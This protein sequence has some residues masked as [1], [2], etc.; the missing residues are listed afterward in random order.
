[1]KVSPARAA[2]FDA[3]LRVERDAAF[4][5]DA[6]DARLE[7]L[8]QRADAALA[9]ELT[10]GVLRW[11][12]LIDFLLERLT[13]RAVAALD[14]EVL[15]GLRLGLYQLRFLSRVPAS[16]AVNESV[17]LVKRARKSSAAGLV[18]ATL[19]RAARDPQLRA[20]AESLVPQDLSA[21]EQLGLA[22]SHPTW[23]VE[24]WLGRYGAPA[25]REL[26]EANNQPPRL[27]AAVMDSE[28]EEEARVS[29]EKAGFDVMPGRWLASAVEL[30]RAPRAGAFRLRDALRVGPL[31][32]QD[33][34]SQMIPLLLDV[35]A[36]QRVLDLCAAPGGKT[37]RLARRAGQGTVVAADVHLHR[38]RPMRELLERLGAEIVNLVALDGTQPLPF[39]ARFD[40]VLVDAPC[41]GTGTLARNPEIRWRLRPHDLSALAEKQKALVRHGLAQL[42]PGGRLVYSTCSLE[43]EENEQ[44]VAAA[45]AAHPGA[46]L[47][48][49]DKALAPHLR[50]GVAAEALFDAQGCFRTFPS[51]HGTD[52]FFAAAI[53]AEA[54]TPR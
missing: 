36:G 12:R 20:A 25:T 16:A 30:R 11:Q 26:L 40:R 22:F 18:N 10:L 8:A 54:G 41:S 23:L 24:R 46:R 29:L 19:R 48:S 17:E 53:E 45:L 6:L 52:G 27:T 49:G 14:L 21:S 33:E 39:S 15:L 13:N 44:V 50:P 43:P 47:V 4:A 1:M 28:W 38:L 34:A 32:L 5:T 51:R 9:T 7:K 2:A 3:L 31:L 35:Q 42:A 37:A